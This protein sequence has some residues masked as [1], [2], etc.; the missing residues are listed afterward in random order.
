MDVARF[1]RHQ[2]NVYYIDLDYDRETN[3][4]PSSQFT[5][6][7]PRNCKEL[8]VLL[9]EKGYK[10]KS[11]L[12][13]KTLLMNNNI[14][15]QE[16]SNDIAFSKIVL[17][18]PTFNSDQVINFVKNIIFENGLEEKSTLKGIIESVK[19]IQLKE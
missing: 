13:M 14:E 17:L 1:N 5:L 9:N 4:N 3:I 8:K 15:E 6:K 12:S 16:F 10:M 18:T 11:I 19:D 2:R 7:K